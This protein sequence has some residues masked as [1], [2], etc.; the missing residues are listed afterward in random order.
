MNI[1]ALSHLHVPLPRTHSPVE[2][3]DFLGQVPAGSDRAARATEPPTRPSW[4][5]LD[6]PGERSELDWDPFD[7]PLFG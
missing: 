1:R 3:G 7:P 2:P 4:P 6:L 5:H